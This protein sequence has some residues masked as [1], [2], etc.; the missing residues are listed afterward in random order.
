MSDT[1]QIIEK[2][3]PQSDEFEALCNLWKAYD[4]MPPIVDD[5]YPEMRHY[6]ERA[7]REFVE[8][9]TLNG[10][11]AKPKTYEEAKRAN[12]DD[13]FQTDVCDELVR[14]RTKFPEPT[15]SMCALTEEVGELA[16]AM[17]KRCAGKGS[18]KD[19]WDEAVQVA[20]MAQRV[21]VEGDVS[22]QRI[23]YREPD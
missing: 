14:A 3:K 16:K 22:M 19:V 12:D 11:L 1:A 9:I 23:A 5:D 13:G 2:M 8:K 7:I 20:A 10:R 4:A 18:S 6:Y 15:F 21:A 17:L